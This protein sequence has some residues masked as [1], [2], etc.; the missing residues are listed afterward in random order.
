VGE[1]IDDTGGDSFG[2]EE[3]C[4]A[5]CIEDGSK[6]EV[7][8]AM[9]W[10]KLQKREIQLSRLSM[11][12]TTDESGTV[13]ETKHGLGDIFVLVQKF[14]VN[15]N[16][17]VILNWELRC[18]WWF[19]ELMFVP[20]V[21]RVGSLLVGGNVWRWMTKVLCKPKS[22][23]GCCCVMQSLWRALQMVVV[24]GLLV[25]RMMPSMLWMLR[26][27]SGVQMHTFLVEMTCMMSYPIMRPERSRG[28]ERVLDMLCFQ[29]EWRA[30]N[31]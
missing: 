29:Q 21:K 23:S 14:G 17:A 13:F 25:E 27:L 20:R 24:C 1:I 28:D 31:Q 6:V 18:S 12:E 8:M 26:V 2:V 16:I 3:G 9:G 4:G 30:K 7:A 15:S 11:R 22:G 10:E 19:V 5:V